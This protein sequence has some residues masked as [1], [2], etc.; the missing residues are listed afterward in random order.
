M[1]M[2]K[3]LRIGR[4]MRCQEWSVKQSKPKYWVMLPIKLHQQMS[5][6]PLTSQVHPQTPRRSWRSRWPMASRGVS[7]SASDARPTPM[8]H[9]HP[10]SQLNAKMGFSSARHPT[11]PALSIS[12]KTSPKCGGSSKRMP[13]VPGVT[14]SA[15]WRRQTTR[16]TAMATSHPRRRN[17]ASLTSL[18]RRSRKWSWSVSSRK[19]LSTT[20]N[21]PTNRARRSPRKQ[22]KSG[23]S[24]LDTRP[25][26]RSTRPISTSMTEWPTSTSKY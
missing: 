12:R 16:A 21:R 2:K 17:R 8:A 18:T 23:A 6:H 22:R 3:T 7:G 5:T 14:V 25:S 24:A 15:Y 20:T 13:E 19:S 9:E 10:Q 11:M 1:R 26:S 4:L